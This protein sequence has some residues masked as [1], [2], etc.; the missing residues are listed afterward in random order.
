MYSCP[1][2]ANSG[3]HPLNTTVIRDRRLPYELIGLEKDL[4]PFDFI[5]SE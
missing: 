2:Q 5:C 4:G 1:E 3:F